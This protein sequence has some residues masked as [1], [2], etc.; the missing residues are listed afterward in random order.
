MISHESRLSPDDR[1][2]LHGAGP[3]ARVRIEWRPDR[4]RVLRSID[5]ELMVVLGMGVPDAVSLD[6]RRVSTSEPFEGEILRSNL[7]AFQRARVARD[8]R[9]LARIEAAE[10][11]H[12][13]ALRR[14]LIEELG[15]TR[16]KIEAL[17]FESFETWPLQAQRVAH[18]YCVT[19]GGTVEAQF[20]RAH[21]RSPALALACEELG[22]GAERVLPE[23]E[24]RER[25]AQAIGS[26]P[27]IDRLADLIERLV[28]E[29]VSKAGAK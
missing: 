22:E 2:T 20:Y 9:E 29:R 11:L 3:A 1:R 21:G 8:G 13:S 4:R 14:F 6:G 15:T 17:A 27:S 7:E 10:E 19:T 12:E 24:D 28:S 25:L 5:G 16:E 18:R 23:H 26:N